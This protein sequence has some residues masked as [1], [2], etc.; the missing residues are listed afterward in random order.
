MKNKYK[1]EELL[2]FIKN[3][4]PNQDLIPLHNPVFVG[5]E[6]KYLS[7]AID[8]TFVSSVGPLVKT[9]EDKLAEFTGIK[10]C[11]ATVNGTSALHIALKAIGVK[12]NTE[13]LTQSLTFI[14]TINAIKYCNAVPVFIDIDL[15]TLGMSH[16]SLENF[17]KFN[18][19]MRNDGK[20]WNKLSNK[21]IKAVMPMHTFGHPV[22]LNKISS[23]CEYYNICLIED[24]SEALGSFYKGKHVGS[25]SI[26]STLS[27]NGNKIIT[28]GGGGAILTNNKELSL[29]MSHIVNTAKIAHKWNFVHDQIGFNYRMPNLNAA[30]GLAQIEQINTY[31]NSKRLLFKR[32]KEFMDNRNFK[33]FEEPQHS[34]SNYW[35]NCIITKCKEERDAL[36]EISHDDKIMMRPAWKPMHQL[37]MFKNCFR[38]ILPNTESLF[39]KIVCIPSSVVKFEK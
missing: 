33:I 38:T 11:T 8:S 16:K 12:E 18:C 35:L 31:L 32:Y 25:H 19:E 22:N 6:K 30:L 23:L 28:T 36:L 26:V 13:V 14:A 24:S 4:Y 29:K 9:F 21:E 17:L 20:C 39:E 7:E 37:P 2:K 34:K 1:Y 27:F 5:N 15:K 10:Y 3:I